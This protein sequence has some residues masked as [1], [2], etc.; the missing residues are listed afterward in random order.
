MLLC[1]CFC[2]SKPFLRCTLRA[3]QSSVFTCA[4]WFKLERNKTSSDLN[5]FSP[6]TSYTWLHEPQSQWACVDLFHLWLSIQVD[7]LLLSFF[8]IVLQIL[9]S[10][11][12]ASSSPA[13]DAL[14]LLKHLVSVRCDFIIVMLRGHNSHRAASPGSSSHSDMSSHM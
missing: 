7:V 8:P 4:G 10:Q 13:Q 2:W 11:S 5:T 9:K 14:T 1:Y 3:E 6:L 12:K